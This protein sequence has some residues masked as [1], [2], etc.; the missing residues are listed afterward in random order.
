[1]KKKEQKDIRSVEDILHLEWDYTEQMLQ[2]T[3]KQWFDQTFPDLSVLLFAAENGGFRTPKSAAM[4][5]YEGMVS[6]APDMVLFPTRYNAAPLGIEMKRPRK[7]ANKMFGITGRAGGVQSDDQKQWQS[8]CE[9]NGGK[10]VVCHGL[11]EF[12]KAVSEHFSL[13]VSEYVTQAVVSYWKYR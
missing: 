7:P 12:V 9:Q 10:Y 2:H 11:I 4:A 13:C 8:V 3:C 1:M 5:K 6:G